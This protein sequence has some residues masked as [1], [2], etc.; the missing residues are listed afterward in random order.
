MIPEDDTLSVNQR[1]DG[2]FDEFAHSTETYFN[3]LQADN[4]H[5]TVKWA[6]YDFWKLLIEY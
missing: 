1:M 6:L 4:L 3:V 5:W 2:F